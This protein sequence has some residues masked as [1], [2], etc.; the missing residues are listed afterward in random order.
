[1]PRT[2][3]ALLID[4]DANTLSAFAEFLR[5]EHCA[6]V[7]E[8]N[9]EAAMRLF[10]QRRFDMVIAD[11]PLHAPRGADLFRR[12]KEIRPGVPIILVT[13][14]PD[15]VTEGKKREQGADYYFLKPLEVVKLRDVVREFLRSSPRVRR[16]PRKN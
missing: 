3:I 1:M 16:V 6:V 10:E 9:G 7:A 13:G 2:Y 14:D 4:E 15:L 11:A 5:K 12:M 8:S